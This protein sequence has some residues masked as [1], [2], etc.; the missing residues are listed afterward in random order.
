MDLIMSMV[1]GPLAPLVKPLVDLTSPA[2]KVLIDLGYNWSGDPGKTQWLSPLPFSLTT[3]PIKVGF[4]LVAAIGEGINN[5]IGG[6][7][8]MM[9]APPNND[10]S[11]LSIQTV[12]DENDAS[13]PDDDAGTAPEG[14]T[15]SDQT[16]A[17]ESAPTSADA[18]KAERDA[19]KAERDAKRATE[20]DERDAAKAADKA[21]KEAAKD[22][23]DSDGAEDHPAAA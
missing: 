18:E 5:V 14:R 10:V 12:A 16:T 23:A 6:G 7:G 21:E 15:A 20:K 3:D 13:T 9:I 2:A 22:A 19:K 17:G 11:A 1:P 8:S 4:D